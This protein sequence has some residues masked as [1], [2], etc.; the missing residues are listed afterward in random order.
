[1]KV[2][3]SS[4]PIISNCA[5]AAVNPKVRIES[6][7]DA[8]NLGT[9]VH[10]VLASWIRHGPE[11]SLIDSVAARD[12]VDVSEMTPLS[13]WGWSAWQSIAEHFPDPEVERG[14]VHAGEDGLILEGH[15]DV[16]ALSAD[17]KRAMI[18]DF[19]SGWIE[20][21]W[22]EQMKAYA[23]LAL[24]HFPGA[25][26]AYAAVLLIRDHTLD[27]SVWTRDEL[28]QWRDE[29]SEHLQ[30]TSIYSPGPHCRY[31]RRALECD[32]N[33]LA[34]TVAGRA[35]AEK[36]VLMFPTDPVE[37]GRV[38]GTLL[39]RVKMVEDLCEQARDA[40]KACVGY[41]GP[42]PTGDGRQIQVRDEERREIDIKAGW[43]IL[44]EELGAGLL[45]GLKVSKT[46]VEKQAMDKAPRG[47]KKEAAQALMKKLDDAGA[48][49]VKVIHKLECR[50]MPA[51]IEQ[52]V[53][54]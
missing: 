22:T 39:D 29:L 14:M 26:S 38:L 34:L 2:R 46:A 16:R 45:D 10:E 17:G 23:W 33:Q 6:P 54:S 42:V 37:R 28:D 15:A 1:M 31:C 3:A 47:K 8:A 19:K 36:D 40:I 30:D 11:S 52:G 51:A 25:E 35:L 50:R 41:G 21:D 13:W 27:A 7:N 49:K 12:G 53:A 32:A 9:A 48:V 44:S 24:R 18:A 20:G 5:A 4:L 43:E